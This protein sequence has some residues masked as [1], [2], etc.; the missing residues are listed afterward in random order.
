M[1]ETFDHIVVGGGSSGCSATSR[2]V[3][4]GARV[5]LLEGGHSHRHPLFD[6][7]PGVFK[8]LKNRSK[9]FTIH[10]STPQEHLDGRTTEIPQDNVLGGRSSV[11]GQAYV[12]GRPS[13]YDGWHETLRGNNDAIGWNWQDVLPRFKCLEGNILSAGAYITPKILMLLD[14]GPADHLTS[15][16]IE[17]IED[18]PGVGQNLN[19]HPDVSIV[20]RANGP[21]GYY[22]QDSGWNMI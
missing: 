19:D 6:M 12:R 11:N 15:H 16:S 18:L 10:E 20:A 3:Q 9:F 8:L 2:L 17:V 13:D 1:T 14:L 21:Y 4:G 22:K 7:P 5:L